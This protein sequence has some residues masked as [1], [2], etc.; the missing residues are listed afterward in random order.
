MLV[1][2]RLEVSYVWGLVFLR[3]D[4]RYSYVWGFVFLLL[5]VSNFYGLEVS[6]LTFE[7]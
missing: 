2:F 3:L 1:F 6:F 4:V 5:G 7:G